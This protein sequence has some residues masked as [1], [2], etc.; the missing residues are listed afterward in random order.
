MA[1][2]LGFRLE[3]CHIFLFILY[4]YRDHLAFYNPHDIHTVVVVPVSG[5]I[6]VEHGVPRKPRSWR[7]A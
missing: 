2:Q 5:I 6:V 7:A 1:I 4:F 3:M